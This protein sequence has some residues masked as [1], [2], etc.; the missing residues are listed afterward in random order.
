MSPAS[1]C[2]GAG[3]RARPLFSGSPVK[4]TRW[5][6]MRKPE[7]KAAEHSGVYAKSMAIPKIK[8]TYSLDVETVRRLEEVARRWGVSKSEALRRAI[9]SAAGQQDVSAPRPLA[10]FRE[11]TRSLALTEEQARDWVASV[12]SERK[13]SSRRLEGQT[14]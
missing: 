7:A 6:G 5:P 8:G 10:V 4:T 14:E 3:L 1:D 2:L 13:A 9:D 12:R 11:L